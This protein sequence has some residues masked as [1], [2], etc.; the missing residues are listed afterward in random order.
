MSKRFGRKHLA[1]A[2]VLALVGCLFA[3]PAAFAGWTTY[4]QTDPSV[5]YVGT[6]INSPLAGHYGGSVLYSS[7]TGNTATFSFTG[8]G[9]RYIAAKWYNRGDA[10]VLL[11]GVPVTPVALFDLYAPGV[12]GD[13]NT[14]TF[15]QQIYSVTGLTHGPHTLTVR[16]NGT[17]NPAA[18]TPYLITVDAFGAY[19]DTDAPSVP[20]N[21]TAAAVST[22]EIEVA[23][24][25]SSDESGVDFYTVHNLT[26]ADSVQV[27]SGTSYTW[28]ALDPDTE[29]EFAVSATDT[30][31]NASGQS[32]SVTA[33]TDA[34]SVSTAAYSLWSLAV[35]AGLAVALVVW[36]RRSSEGRR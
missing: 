8:S 11:D 10:Q 9:V 22:S 1:A 28:S 36:R 16:V 4:D 2:F 18:S 17:H 20:A 5:A 33:T 25:A 30:R 29:Y 23:W 14:V 34:E 24:D 19:S 26:T 31:G 6:W 7:T 32:G 35:L 12:A 27:P 3:A 13:T 15:Q 21:V